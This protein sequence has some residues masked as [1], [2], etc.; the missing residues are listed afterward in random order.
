MCVVSKITYQGVVVLDLLHGGLG[1]QGVL[2]DGVGVQALTGGNR[3]T[4]V[5]G[6]AGVLQGLG[7]VERHREAGLQG[8]LSGGL[9]DLLGRGLSLRLRV[10]LTCGMEGGE[11]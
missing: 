3:G 10:L 8:L 5:L 4:G 6:L 2:D 11:G 7:A 1:R 9:L